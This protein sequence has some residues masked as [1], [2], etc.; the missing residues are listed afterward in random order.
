M[1]FFITVIC[2]K[3]FILADLNQKILTNNIENSL[4]HLLKKKKTHYYLVTRMLV[5][6]EKSI[7][8]S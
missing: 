7:F 2:V 8:K 3:I 1:L 6:F 5:K 4:K